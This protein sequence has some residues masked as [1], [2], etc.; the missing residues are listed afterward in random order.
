MGAL[1]Q[2]RLLLWKNFLTQIRSPWFTLMEF[3]VPLILIGA[4][5]GLM[6]GLRG[7]FEKSYD[8]IYYEPWPVTGSSYDLVMPADILKESIK[9][10]VLDLSPFITGHRDHCPFLQINQTGNNTWSAHLELA[11]APQPPHI[12]DIMNRVAARYKNPNVFEFLPTIVNLTAHFGMH[13]NATILGNLLNS[14]LATTATVKGFD[15]ESELVTY[16]KERFQMQCG[17]PLLA[18]IV[19]EDSFTKDSTANNITYKIRLSNTKRRFQPS[20]GGGYHPWDTK[21]RFAIQFV[22]G[23]QQQKQNDGGYPG[24]WREGFL[25]VQRAIDVAIQDQALNRTTAVSFDTEYLTLQRFPFPAYKSQ[26]IEIG[27]F[28]LPVIIIFSFMTSVIYIVRS[29]VMEKE[30]RLKEYM[31]VMGLSQWIHWVAYFIVSYIKLFFTVLVLSILMYFVMKKSDPTVAFVFYLLYAFDATYFAFAISTFMQS[32]TAG[33]MMAVLGWML[34]YFWMVVINGMDTQSPY[35]FATR[36]AN[37]LNPDIAL[38]FGID[39][40][41][42]HETQSGGLFWSNVW[43]RTSPD[44]IL[45]IGHLL[46]M[47]AVDGVILIIIT[48]YVEAVNPGGEGVPQKPWFFVLPSYWFPNC[49]AQDRQSMDSISRGR[50]NNP[51]AKIEEEPKNV[52]TT[53]KVVNL[54]KTYGTSFFKKLFDCKFGKEGEKK[55]VDHLNLNMYHGQITALLG[56]N[57]AGKSTTFS[58]LTG[59]TAPS[60]GTAYVDGYDIRTSL[61]QIRKSLGLCPQYN[62]LFDNLTVM[63]HLE[64]FCKLKGR[65]YF[66][67]EAMDILTRLKIDFKKDC[68]AG[69]LSGGQKRK[70]SLSIALIGGSEI[71]MLDE[72]TSGMDPGARHETWTLLQAEKKSRSML[73]TTH[74]MEEA[75]LLGDRIAIMAHGQLQCCGSGM[76]LKNEYG[77]GYHLTVVYKRVKDEQGQDLYAQHFGPDTKKVLKKFSPSVT[78]HSAV[79]QEATFLLPATDR[80]NFP[81]MF[82][83]LETHQRELNINSFGVSIT[84][85]EEVFLKV[86]DLANERLKIDQDEDLPESTERIAEDDTYLKQLRVNRRLTGSKYFLQHANAMFRKRVIYFY[87]KWTQF[88]PQLFIPILYMALLVWASTLAPSASD[89]KPLTISM[90]TY[91]DS[92]NPAHV[93]VQKDNSTWYGKQNLSDYVKTIIEDQAPKENLVIDT[94]GNMSKTILEQTKKQGQ[95]KF[96]IYNPI[97]FLNT[98]IDTGFLG[99]FDI[100]NVFFENYGVHTPPLAVNLGDMALMRNALNRSINLKVI[101]HP[102]PPTGADKLKNKNVSDGPA[103]VLAYAIIVSMAMVV[104]GYASFLIRERK[105][106][107]KHMQMMSGLRPWMYWAS[108]FIWDAV[109]YLLPVACFIGIYF[110]F[111]VKPLTSRGDT[112][113]TLILV[114]L[115][116][117][118]NTIPFVYS[119]SFAFNTAPKGYTMIVMYHVI[120]GM[121][122]T[123]AVPIIKQTANEDVAFTWSIIFSWFFPVYSISNCYT[124]IYNNEATRQACSSIDCSN[125]FYK[126][127]IAQCCGSPSERSFVDSVLSDAGKR[128]IMVPIIFFSIQ[129]FIFWFTTIAIENGWFDQ[130]KAKIR[131]S[132]KK[133]KKVKSGSAANGT[134]KGHINLSFDFDD[135]RPKSVE[136]SDVLEEK[137]I[138][139]DMMPNQH[140]IIVNDLKKWYGNFNAVKGVSFHVDIRDCFG[141]LGVNGAGKTSTFQMLTGENAVSD[142]DALINGYS[143]RDDWRQ[144]GSHIGY[145]PQY[146]AIIKEMSG[147]ET[148]YMFARLRGIYEEDIPQMVNAV[149]QAIGIGIYAKRQIKTYSGGNK[150]RLSLGIALVGLPDVLLLDEPTTGVDPKARRIIWN[151]LS[152]VREQGT[153]LVLTSHSMEECEAL[154]TSLAIMVYGQ[155]RCL[156]SAQHLKSR[157]GAGYTLLV[158]LQDV[159]AS[160]KVKSEIL[161]R[162]PGSMLKEE[163]VL[164][165]NFELRKTDSV[166]W[167]TLFAQMEQIVEPLR[168]A[169]YSLSQTT[170]E[171]VFLEFSRDAGAVSD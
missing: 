80:R 13:V 74:Y 94:T 6:I 38:S 159:D 92:K 117:G 170:L 129:G 164:Q 101:N 64:F 12:V 31:K 21:I 1:A 123:I 112:V 37:C 140:T 161:R 44:Q 33:T 5:F 45:T 116:F 154:C 76:Y 99:T 125:A 85:M 55:A 59:V 36:I 50:E 15:T 84:T 152:K 65:P 104:S 82:K 39:L 57:G 75:D 34:L 22:S 160:E 49:A 105:K 138:I 110:A 148:L 26:I 77:A 126:T 113:G 98:A 171:Q 151:I 103:F 119:F 28:F 23:P 78:M 146:D 142:G 51:Y 147:E 106:K 89:Q 91:G 166:T 132:L 18:G 4:A 169:D 118:W 8:N 90:S 81:N 43:Q 144:A 162:F 86:G 167:S 122:G 102:L 30:N 111:D 56:H 108:A 52:R 143:V 128:G 32:G 53:I 71:V 133:Q 153:A 60:G 145:C 136:D 2:L 66:V 97:G 130:M 149:V 14:S 25:T 11:Y 150:R 10:S 17:N 42:Q 61:P 54:C 163:H 83:T 19:F 100:M 157:Y 73:L 135:G 79:G 96:G 40:M 139:N 95:R 27:A 155:F 9:E 70:L 72:P 115:L 47:L 127:N 114:M 93:Y 141:L 168:I 165:L 121:V 107:S 48:W 16:M 62:I 58:M 124:T 35:P 88:I 46:I 137:R 158:R 41:A 63:E 131:G 156:G 24:Y 7:T 69:T 87:R 3:L 109:C 20:F 67:S 68:Y 29:V 134:S 120:T